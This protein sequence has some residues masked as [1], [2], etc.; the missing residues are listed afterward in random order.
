MLEYTAPDLHVRHI[1]PL[2]CRHKQPL[3]LLCSPR[4]FMLAAF[5]R[6]PCRLQLSVIW[7]CRGSLCCECR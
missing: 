3:T 7:Y 4:R 5:F 6:M 2:M 1:G